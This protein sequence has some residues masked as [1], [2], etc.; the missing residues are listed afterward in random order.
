MDSNLTTEELQAKILELQQQN[1]QL[2]TQNNAMNAELES[3]KTS[4]DQ[5]RKLNTQ[6]YHQMTFVNPT[7]TI[8]NSPENSPEEHKETMDEFIDSFLKPAVKQLKQNF[9][10]DNV[11]DIN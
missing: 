4:L 6:Y 8:P 5:S 7:P 2:T 9:G 10:D 11:A 1:E 3:T